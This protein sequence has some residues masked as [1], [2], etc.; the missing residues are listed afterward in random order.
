[1][2]LRALPDD[3]E[4]MRYRVVACD[5]DGTLASGGIVEENTVEALQRLRASGRAAVLVTG[6]E[7]SDLLRIFPHPELFDRIVAENGAVLYTPATRAHRI[8]A[9]PAPEEFLAL[10]RRK[11]VQPLSAGRVIVSTTESN[12]PAVRDA[13]RSLGLDLHIERNKG[14]AMV[15][16]AGIDKATGLS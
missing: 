16:P 3:D 9:E 1:M 10:L 5:Y 8:L 7:L 15:L 13:I 12:E 11:Q 4:I 6:R 14:A 2:N